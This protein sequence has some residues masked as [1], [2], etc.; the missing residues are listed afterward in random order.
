VAKVIAAPT[1]SESKVLERR[2]KAKHVHF[3]LLVILICLASVTFLVPDDVAPL[4]TV[5]V[6][7]LIC[8]VAMSS[9]N[10]QYFQKCPRCEA[11]N[12][13]TQGSCLRCGLEYSV[14]KPGR[15]AESGEK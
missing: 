13:R 14:T 12:A 6:G 11:K 15:A 8:L 7:A 4:M 5:G 3:V 10:L 9:V 1:K 2:S